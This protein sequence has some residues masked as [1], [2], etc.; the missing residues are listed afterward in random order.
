LA[1]HALLGGGPLLPIHWGTFN[2]ALHPWDD[3]IEKLVELA[4]ATGTRLVLPKLG[5][6]VEPDHDTRIEPWWRGVDSRSGGTTIVEPPPESLP[7]GMPW[8]LD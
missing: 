7:N 8:P 4:P 1:A 3:P 6:P 5:Q 2:L